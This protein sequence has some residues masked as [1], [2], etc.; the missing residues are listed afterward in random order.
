MGNK[1]YKL[2]Y[3]PLFEQDL[4][5]TANY[6]TNV[7]KNEDAA[8]RLVDDVMEVRRL[9]YGARRC[10]QTFVKVVKRKKILSSG[11][12]LPYKWK[13]LNSEGAFAP[14]FFFIRQ[15]IPIKLIPGYAQENI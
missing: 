14:L 1:S 5:S 10:R 13:I 12:F 2:R 8:I 7:L 15:Y 4:I 9:M 11:E 3:L 6:I